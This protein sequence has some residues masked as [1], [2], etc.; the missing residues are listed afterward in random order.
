MQHNILSSSIS[1]GEDGASKWAV[2]IE[3]IRKIYC[4]DFFTFAGK[5]GSV[6]EVN[7]GQRLR[8]LKS[9]PPYSKPNPIY[10]RSKVLTHDSDRILVL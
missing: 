5:I 1:C 6:L 4:L 10:R 7:R 2:K 3:L 9:P 8:K